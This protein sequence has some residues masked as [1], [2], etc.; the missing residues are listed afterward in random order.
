M[1]QDLNQMINAGFN[2]YKLFL[3]KQVNPLPSKNGANKLF[4]RNGADAF[5]TSSGR[6]YNNSMKSKTL[7][8][9]VK[10]TKQSK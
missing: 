1:G 10:E 5:A 8:S 4:F 9:E 7:E 2:T 3:K 6:F